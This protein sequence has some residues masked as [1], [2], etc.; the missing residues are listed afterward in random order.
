MSYWRRAAETGSRRSGSP[1]PAPWI[2]CYPALRMILGRLREGVHAPDKITIDVGLQ[3]GG[4]TGF[5][6]AKGTAEAS[7]AVSMTWR[8][9]SDDGGGEGAVKR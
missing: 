1:W 4:E 7:I 3:V 6:F 8:R 2:G 9:R 5:V